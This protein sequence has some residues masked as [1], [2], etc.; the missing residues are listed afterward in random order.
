M[1]AVIVEE[2]GPVD[3]PRVQNVPD[4]VPAKD[5]V[6]IENHAAGVN[7]P[8]AMVIE[9]TYQVRP[10]VPFSPGKEL[11]GIVSAVGDDVNGIKPGDRVI[12]QIE[13][14]AWAER[15][16]V[17][18]QNC[19]PV[20]AQLDFAEAVSLGLTYQTAWFALNDRS[21]Y[22]NGETVLV[23]G[24]AGGVGL[25]AVQLASAS[26]ARVIAGVRHEA[27]HDLVRAHGAT[28]VVDLGADDL[29]NT[30]KQQVMSLTDGDGVDIVL[31][32][33]GGDV[34]DACLRTLNFCGR[35]VV[36]GFA[37]GQIPQIKAGLILVKNISITGL[38]W[39]LYREQ[40]LSRVRDA[41][42]QIFDLAVAG[43]LKPE[44][45]DRFGL[46]GFADALAAL[47]AGSLKG[48][49]VIEPLT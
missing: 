40:R 19:C 30:L 10:P 26:G 9:G 42:K 11:A 47:R 39:A 20:P 8:D 7:F 43:K 44:I 24:A 38:N 3:S 6:V 25:A 32:N 5:E 18:A 23:T 15:V 36:I 48:Q 2:I 1:R 27:Q 37:G 46:D 28:H 14:G 31:E 22:R 4:P 29:R 41:Q 17:P 21:Q 34:F 12:A 33:I 45:M 13:Y 35:V 49:F 16:A